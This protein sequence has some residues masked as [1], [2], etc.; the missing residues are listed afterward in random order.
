MECKNCHKEIME[1]SKFCEFCG[2]EIVKEKKRFKI[3]DTIT[4]LVLAIFST[5]IASAGIILPFINITGGLFNNYRNYSNV[6]T[7]FNNN[8]GIFSGLT[9][10]V[11]S[12]HI[13]G[14]IVGYVLVI[15]IMGL[16]VALLVMSIIKII[17]GNN[18]KALDN[19]HFINFFL[20]TV[21]LTVFGLDG[22]LTITLMVL[23]SLY[24]ITYMVIKIIN[25]D[26][27]L[28]LKILFGIGFAFF[29]ISFWTVCG[30]GGNTFDF[31]VDKASSAYNNY[32]YAFCLYITTLCLYG[33]SVILTLVNLNLLTSNK[34]MASS[35]ISFVLV[36]MFISLTIT[37][38]IKETSVMT[39]SF[40]A[41]I[42]LFLVTSVF[43]LVVALLSNKETRKE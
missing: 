32:F 16:S 35:I 14:L 12:A 30:I 3:S 39:T 22:S 28:S 34:K 5:V 8:L 40:V 15:G 38:N 9:G 23:Y 24:Y 13:K 11:Y 6:V 1:D 33:V 7:Y 36:F 31:Y 25:G 18:S 4:S 2:H 27:K 26:E 42:A 43:L 17:N 20:T 29:L 41:P 19:L 10:G 37:S 21:G